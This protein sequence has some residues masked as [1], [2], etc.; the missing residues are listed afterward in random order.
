[1]GLQP[2]CSGAGTWWNAI[3][4]NI[5]EPER[6]SGKYSHRRN[7]NTEAFRQITSYSLG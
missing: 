1:M 3:P 4:A 2:G 6:H 7:A 5:V